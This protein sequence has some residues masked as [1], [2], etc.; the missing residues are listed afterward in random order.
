MRTLYVTPSPTPNP[1]TVYPPLCVNSFA[2]KQYRD[3]LKTKCCREPQV[4]YFRKNFR[5]FTAYGMQKIAHPVRPLMVKNMLLD[6]TGYQKEVDMLIPEYVTFRLPPISNQ[7]MLTEPYKGLSVGTVLEA[8]EQINA[9]NQTDSSVSL[10]KAP[11]PYWTKNIASFLLDRVVWTVNNQQIGKTYGFFIRAWM[12]INERTLC[13][14][15]LEEQ[16]EMAKKPT[17]IKIPLL[18]GF[19][20]HKPYAYFNK[21]YIKSSS[22][23]F[24]LGNIRSCIHHLDCDI[25]NESLRLATGA[26]TW[27]TVVK[28]Q[29]H[30]GTENIGTECSGMPQSIKQQHVGMQVVSTGIIMSEFEIKR[31]NSVRIIE[32]VKEEWTLLVKQALP[33][34]RF[35]AHIT[36]PTNKNLPIHEILWFVTDDHGWNKSTQNFMVGKTS[37]GEDG[38]VT[39]FSGLEATKLFVGKYCTDG[40]IQSTIASTIRHFEKKDAAFMQ[41]LPNPFISALNLQKG[42]GRYC[43]GLENAVT[44][45]TFE[46]SQLSMVIRYNKHIKVPVL[47]VYAFEQETMEHHCGL[48]QQ[49]KMA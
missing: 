27:V 45:F 8:S 15:A 32:T 20:K 41:S 13:P 23:A 49:K 46:E 18:M 25:I 14:L 6:I 44:F 36:I 2:K 43:F 47:H 28:N 7:V 10:F 12:E 22:F 26:S 9:K 30:I 48:L 33:T 38:F 21:K 19:S 5:R 42:I 16:K 1:P 31:F 3:S 40:R 35:V 34:D 29:Q 39:G 11:E 4:T 24:T 17:W 37:A